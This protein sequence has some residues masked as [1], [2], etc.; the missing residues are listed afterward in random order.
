MRHTIYEGVRNRLTIDRSDFYDTIR[1][2]N[3]PYELFDALEHPSRFCDRHL[4]PHKRCTVDART[5]TRMYNTLVRRLHD[6]CST[7]SPKLQAHLRKK[8]CAR[9]S[10]LLTIDSLFFNTNI[11]VI[12]VWLAC[13]FHNEGVDCDDDYP[14]GIH[15][16]CSHAALL[17]V[18]L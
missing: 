7:F 14:G 8:V 17:P 6:V 18:Q 3:D 1:G 16:D 5:L 10:A 4:P 12:K 13:I 9:C 15:H 11:Q 2:S